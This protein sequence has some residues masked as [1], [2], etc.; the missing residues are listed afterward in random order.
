MLDTEEDIG[1]RKQLSNVMYNKYKGKIICKKLSLTTRMRL[2]RTY[3]T[4]VFMYNCEIW[5]LTK[6][7]EN[8]IDIFH[9]KFLRNILN[10]K[11][12]YVIRNEELYKR[13][14]EEP[15]SNIIRRRRL[16]W[17][18]HLHRIPE[19]YPAW[20]AFEESQRISGT[21]KK[22]RGNKLTWKKQMTNDLSSIKETQNTSVRDM[23]RDRE[24]WRSVVVNDAAMFTNKR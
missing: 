12:P 22:T 23:A 1:R 17:T 14:N 7:L 2:F 19:N 5:T 18:G 16:R 15:W 20:I 3:V 21:M 8:D 4:S 6:K 13:T 11:Y 10:I 9:R 24:W